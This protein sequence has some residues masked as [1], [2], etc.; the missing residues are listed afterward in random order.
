MSCNRAR[1]TG[2]P[3]APRPISLPALSKIQKQALDALHFLAER[4]A[5]KIQ[6]Q[7][8]D[9]IFFNNLSMLHARDAFVDSNA[10]GN[11]R[12]LLRLI[13][14]NSR[15]E[16]HELPPQLAETWKQLYEHDAEEEILPI[17]KQLFSRATEH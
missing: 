17:E 3:S 16:A 8:G 9:M 14:K 2:T 7:P 15:D 6:L 11:K 10:R 5:V 4:R 12:H 13:L 1:I